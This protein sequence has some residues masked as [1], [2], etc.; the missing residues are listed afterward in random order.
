MIAPQVIV[1]GRGDTLDDNYFVHT[2]YFFVTQINVVFSLKKTEKI[3]I[4]YLNY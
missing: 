2:N 4:Y 3:Y 1:V